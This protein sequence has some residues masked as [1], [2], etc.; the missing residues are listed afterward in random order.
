[1]KKAIN[2]YINNKR[3]E[4][5]LALGGQPFYEEYKKDV[6]TIL[7]DTIKYMQDNQVHIY[8]YDIT[9]GELSYTLELS[10]FDINKIY[11]VEWI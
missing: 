9:A 1:M 10:L 2:T 3:M 8:E 11:N 6:I 5:D 4:L 7:E